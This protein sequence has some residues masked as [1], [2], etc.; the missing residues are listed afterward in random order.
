MVQ[1][2]QNSNPQ[3]SYPAIYSSHQQPSA[4][5]TSQNGDMTSQS[6]VMTSQSG[7][8]TSQSGMMTSHSPM[9]SSEPTLTQPAL[10][11]GTIK[12][13]SS[14]KLDSKQAELENAIL[15]NNLGSDDIDNIFFDIM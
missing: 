12:S 11:E 2:P 6:G 3:P 7:M 9:T 8:M 1:Q 4:M 10:N 5:M 14:P 13:S 15:D